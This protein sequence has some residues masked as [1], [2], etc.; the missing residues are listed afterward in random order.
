MQYSL[1]NLNAFIL[2]I[3]IGYSLYLYV[4]KKPDTV[5]SFGG[6]NGSE[7]ETKESDSASHIL[8]TNEIKDLNNSPI[9]LINQMKGYFYINPVLALSLAI[10]VFSFVGVPP[11]VGFFAKQMVLSSALD[12]G[13]VFITLIAILASVVSAYYYLALVKQIFFHK[14]D[15]ILNPVLENINLNASIVSR[16]ASSNTQSAEQVNI[17]AHN[18]RLSSSLTATISVLTLI[19]LLFILIP[20]E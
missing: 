13:Y 4:E 12:N 11:L 15:Y 9:Q 18:I 19:I 8:L 1:T 5:S 14:T 2:L 7:S 10:T 3:T 17:N 6:S 20:Q 16:T